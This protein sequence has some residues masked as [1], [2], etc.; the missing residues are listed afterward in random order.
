[1]LFYQ[2]ASYDH[3]LCS[4]NNSSKLPNQQLKPIQTSFAL[5][6]LLGILR[7][8]QKIMQPDKSTRNSSC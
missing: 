1:M 2:R 5:G 8:Q 7:P 6:F 4:Q 3:Y